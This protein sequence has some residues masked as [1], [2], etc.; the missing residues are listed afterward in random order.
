MLVRE[1]EGDSCEGSEASLAV[2]FVDL[3]DVTTPESVR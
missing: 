2:C 1:G 3:S